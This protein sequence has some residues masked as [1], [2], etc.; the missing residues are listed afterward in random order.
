MLGVCQSLLPQLLPGEQPAAAP[1]SWKVC[2]GEQAVGSE[3]RHS[4]KVRSQ[5]PKR[6]LGTD[7]LVGLVAIGQEIMV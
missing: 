5:H 6:C 3:G 4:P 7:L 2:S 1:R